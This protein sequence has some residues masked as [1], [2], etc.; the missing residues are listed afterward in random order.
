MR[1][2]SILA[3]A[4]RRPPWSRSSARP[5]RAPTT[6]T[7]ARSDRLKA[8]LKG[9]G[10]V[11]AVS[12]AARGSFRAVLSEDESEI[13]YRLDY[14]GLQ[15][16][17]LQAHI[18]VGDHHTNGGISVWLCGNPARLRGQPARRHADLRR[19]R[20]AMDPRRRERSPPPT[21]SARPGS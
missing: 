18:H 17:V 16:N 8:D 11:P 1:R 5:R 19:R 10:E 3:S 7:G 2:K 12:T 14:A 20:R 6:T 9:F 4:A 13:A 21:S 15:G